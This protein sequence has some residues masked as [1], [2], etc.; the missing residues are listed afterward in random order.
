MRKYPL[1][2][3]GC[4]LS[5][6][7]AG[8]RFARFGQKV[9]ILERHA[10]PGGLNSYYYRQ[11]RL[12]ETGLHAITNFAAADNKHA[13][14]NRL[15]RQ[16]KIPRRT[17]NLREQYTSEILF[18]GR[19]SICFSNNF[20]LIQQQI[21]SHFPDSLHH[22]NDMVAEIDAYDPFT[23]RPK[24]SAKNFVSLFLHDKL[25]VEMLF[26]PVMFYGC[27]DED[28]MDL[29]QFVILF[30]SIFQ[31]GFFRPE[32][33]IKDFLDLLLGQ[34]KKF[35]GDLQLSSGVKEIITTGD[36]ITGVRTAKGEE[37]GCDFLMSTAGSPETKK[38]FSSPEAA[39]LFS[40]LPENKNSGRLSFTESIYL[41]DKSA[42]KI[43]PDNRTI[44]FYNLAEDFSYHR[45]DEAVDLN[46]GVIC[47]SDNFQGGGNRDTIQLRVT[48]LANYSIWHDAYKADDKSQY[49]NLKTLWSERS[50]EVVGKI[51][52]NYSKN[53]V[54]EDTFTPATIERYT[55]RSQGAVYGSPEKIKDG[56]T[57]FENLYIA[58]TDQGYLGIVGSMLSGV[59]MVNQH[60]LN[61]V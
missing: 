39:A 45:P 3:I 61:K 57:G 18:P 51:I 34:Y 14:L 2:I 46:S 53:I 41:L 30:R 60:I 13:P 6:L 25:L 16:L 17:L 44:I 42:G 4:G 52:G 31:E 29:S 12:L 48:H 49:K 7:A 8:I 54:Y 50:K 35:G 38:L 32:G 15:L 26:C 40:D 56:Q 5:G 55:S 33:T 19:K 36:T 20:E 23:P 47:F 43:L 24:I 1:L 28:D 21:A 37:I 9:L 59:S 58:G 10:K 22:F 11:G 27:S